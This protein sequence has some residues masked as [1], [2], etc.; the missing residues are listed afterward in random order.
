MDWSKLDPA[1]ILTRPARPGRRSWIGVDFDAERVHL[2]QVERAGGGLRLREACS[3]PHG[4]DLDALLASGPELKRLFSSVLRGSRFKGRHV[5][6]TP[7][8]EALR[9]M[10]LSY[11]VEEERSEPEQ[12]LALTR[13]RVRDE[14]DAYVVDYMPIRA[15][16]GQE[17][18]RSA[19]VAV[20]REDAVIEH[21]ERLRGAGLIVEALDVAPA[22]V[23]RLVTTATRP[24]REGHEGGVALVLR[25]GSELTELSVVAGR[26]LLLYRE[27]ETGTHTLAAAAAK[28][29]DCEEEAAI[30][31]I[32]AFGVGSDGGGDG[33]APLQFVAGLEEDE[34][35]EAAF[36]NTLRE[37]LRPALRGLAEQA[38]KAIAYAAFQMRGTP[39]DRV[40]LIEGGFHCP[41]LDG[42]L[43]EM[44]QLPVQP[45]RPLAYL[46]SAPHHA[47]LAND[48]RLTLALGH[49]LRGMSD[50]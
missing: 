1:A 45:L 12:I 41:G 9:L 35:G 18:E 17:G 5:V 13:E 10:V 36:T 23:R 47:S 19:I 24:D 38:H 6:T 42:L 33:D 48:G 49:A 22:A 21:L 7:P 15:G 11:A 14:L 29:L 25:L 31:L 4:G 26:R 2:V 34:L 8:P 3:V 30:E 39:I 50:G 28:G 20:A 16:E 44:L 27:I 43:S 40:L 32:E 37:V 46:P